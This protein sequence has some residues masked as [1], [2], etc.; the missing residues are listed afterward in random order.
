[1]NDDWSTPTG[2]FEPNRCES[3]NGS[4]DPSRNA[5]PVDGRDVGVAAGLNAPAVVR[6]P[7][8]DRVPAAV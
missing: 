6:G 8:V 2:E 5:G 3:V 4:A 7:K 1:M